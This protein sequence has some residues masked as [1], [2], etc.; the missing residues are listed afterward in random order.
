[1]LSSSSLSYCDCCGLQVATLQTDCPRCGYP[2]DASREE[3]FL[4]HALD[5]LQ[6]V[7][8]YGG[9][10]LTITQLL[11]RYQ[12]RL[13]YLEQQKELAHYE[14]EPAVINNQSKISSQLSPSHPEIMETQIPPAA[15]V[16]SPALSAT[17]AQSGSKPAGKMFSLKSF[18]ED[19]TINIVASLGAF[20]ILVGS[21]SFIST[22]TNLVL[23]F[24]LMFIVHAVFGAVG[25][26]SYRFQSFRIVAV[27][28]TAIFALLIPLVGFSGYRLVTNNLVPIATPLLI[29]IAAI[30]AALIYGMLAVYQRFSLFAYL[31][32]VALAVADL[33]LAIHFHLTVRWWPSTLMVLAFPALLSVSRLPRSRFFSGHWSVLRVPVRTLMYSCVTVCLLGVMTT[34]LLSLLASFEYTVEDRVALTAMLLL[35]LCWSGLFVWRT[36]HTGVAQSL[37]LQFLACALAFSYANHASQTKYILVLIGIAFLYHALVRFA[38]RLLQAFK[39]MA[40]WLDAISIVL[41]ALIP[42]IAFPDLIGRT[43]FHITTLNFTYLL[44]P[45]AMTT[46]TLIGLL[47]VSAGCLLTLSILQHHTKFQPTLAPQQTGWPWLLLLTDFLLNTAFSV[48]VLWLQSSMLGSFFGLALTLIALAILVRNQLSARWAAP[49][50]IVALFSIGQV[51]ALGF[52]EPLEVIIFLLLF[53][54]VLT[55]GVALYQRRPLLLI[56]PMLLALLA[57]PPLTQRLPALYITTV[58]LPFLAMFLYRFLAE[59]LYEEAPSKTGYLNWIQ[60]DWPLLSAGILYGCTFTIY[61]AFAP[62]STVQ[63]WTGIG[64]PAGMEVALIAIAW[65]AAAALTQLKRRLLIAAGFA[66]LALL[67]PTNSFWFLTWLAP[68]LA[69][70][71]FGVSRLAGRDWALPFYTT[72][73]FAAI[74]MGISGYMHG[75]YLPTTYALLVFAVDIYLIGYAEHEPM[76]FWIAVAFASSS[77]Y[78][79]GMIGGFYRFFPP[80][81]ALSCTTLGIGI[82]G[83]RWLAPS[84]P[85]QASPLQYSLPLYVIA[86]IAAVFTGIYGLI[87]G[88]NNPSYT[89]IPDALLLY[90]LIAYIVVSFER[91]PHYQWVVAGFAICGTLSA[92]QLVTAPEYLW[93]GTCTSTLCSIQ[94]QNAVYYL[95][96]VALATGLA[97]LLTH[98]F[99]RGARFVW[100]WSWYLS[101]LVAIVTTASW[102]YG[103][104]DYVP[105]L[106]ILCA[107]ILLSLIIL[108]VE[109]VPEIMIVPVALAA[110]TISLVHWDLWQQMIGYTLLCTLIFGSQFIWQK[111]PPVPLI[112]TP[113]KLHQL[114]GLGGQICVVLVIIGQGG[115]FTSAGT[116]AHVG[117]GALLVLAAL[118]FWF[119]RLQAQ[120]TIRRWCGYTAGLLLALAASW[121][122]AASG[123]T[124]LDVLSLAPASYLIIVSPFVSR[125]ETLPYHHQTGQWCAVIGAILLL[126]PAL[127]LSFS[128]ENLQPTLILAG[129]AL[130][131]LL[132]GVGLRVRFFVL[133]GAA[134]V[135]VAAMHALFLPLLGLPP[136]LALTILGGTLLAIATALS[137]ARHRL[138]AAWTQWQ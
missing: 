88:V 94:A 67:M 101:S 28:Y 26:I 93:H 125:D 62:V 34:F 109:R 111:L 72:A 118:L 80:I 136:S 112:A 5:D 3:S 113:Q 50:D 81:I 14:N 7:I 52:N 106:A 105:F 31:A 115:L 71:A 83:L 21:L 30:Y 104:R 41:V 130:V 44:E 17:N 78:C 92:T 91:K 27:I 2:I 63:S 10:S 56:L 133:S 1:M 43:F 99:N 9:A 74:M 82:G 37:T 36:R 8:T 39:D 60:W 15:P 98:L 58:A 114:I 87:A 70:L 124:H 120:A 69:L 59:Y 46:D 40:A 135:I 4:H 86:F 119:G 128:A 49:L 79:S 134:L 25:I 137:L 108:L 100:N 57:L 96:G 47:A 51:L 65:Y 131:L 61:D 132:L 16:F 68:I 64:F 23:A 18:L 38:G 116:L 95:T 12:A 20:L 123:Q 73:V 103:A 24:L 84:R 53:F 42:L 110:W 48:V 54:A 129:E 117:A 29:S 90:A 102:G 138:R 66:L 35:L 97:G 6:R 33:A 122:L 76:L 127:W 126:A 75:L 19:Q 77:L 22:T 45:L 13:N 121:E 85:T 89:A 11:Q 32:V 107:F 55:Y